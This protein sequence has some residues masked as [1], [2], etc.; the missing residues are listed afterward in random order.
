MADT[1]ISVRNAIIMD[2]RLIN[3]TLV[4]LAYIEYKA[5]VMRD[6]GRPFS[7]EWFRYKMVEAV[8]RL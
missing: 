7:F 6:G 4:F 5:E 3:N 2:S 8:S 1:F